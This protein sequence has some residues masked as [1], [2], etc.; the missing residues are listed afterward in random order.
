MRTAMMPEGRG[1]GAVMPR[2]FAGRSVLKDTRDA[3]FDGWKRPVWLLSIY[4][5][6]MASP[7]KLTEAT[8][9]AF[10][11]ARLIRRGKL[12]ALAVAKACSHT[13]M[14]LPVEIPLAASVGDLTL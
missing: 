3:V 13:S 10:R 12:L 5:I 14:S 7:D 9:R 6:V 4:A 2:G 11:S 8:G 1:V